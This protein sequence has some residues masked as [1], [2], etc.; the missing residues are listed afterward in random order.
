MIGS[1]P[2]FYY[3]GY[4]GAS[5]GGSPITPSPDI[6]Q[7]A[8]RVTPGLLNLEDLPLSSREQGY[9]ELPLTSLYFEFVNHS[10]HDVY[11]SFH[12]LSGPI[13]KP[14]LTSLN[15]PLIKVPCGTGWESQLL[16]DSGVTRTVVWQYFDGVEPLGELQF[17]THVTD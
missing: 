4:F 13:T 14:P 6:S 3:S 15:G 1:K 17:I 12:D 11:L 2:L 8:K 10:T 9:Y 16:L 7:K 5:G